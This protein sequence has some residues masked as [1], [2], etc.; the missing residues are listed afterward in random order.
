MVARFLASQAIAE[1]ELQI[2]GVDSLSVT[3]ADP[4]FTAGPVSIGGEAGSQRIAEIRAG[5]NGQDLLDGLLRLNR[6]VLSGAEIQLER[7][8]DGNFTVPGLPQ[9]SDDGRADSMGEFA[10]SGVSVDLVELTDSIIR[11]QDVN[12]ALFELS[13]TRAVF[14]GIG[15]WQSGARTTFA[16]DGSLNGIGLSLEGEVLPVGERRSLYLFGNLNNITQ[17]ID[18]TLVKK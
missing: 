11:F 6:L 4:G 9:G 16:L 14:G 3:L 13:V 15:A 12:G 10:E 1:Y 8:A 7:D 18:S 5:L 17:A 2:D